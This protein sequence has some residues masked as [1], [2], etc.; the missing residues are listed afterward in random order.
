[1]K[2]RSG[3]ILIIVLLVVVVALAVG[4]SVASRNITNLRTSTQTEQSQRAFTAAEGG[5]EDVLSRLSTITSG[6]P[7]GGQTTV[8]VPVG[9]LTA[10]VSI[11]SANTYQQVIDEGNVGQIALSGGSGTVQ[12]EWVNSSDSSESGNPA[13][14]EITE[15]NGVSPYTQVR[16]AWSGADHGG[17]QQGFVDPSTT[18]LSAPYHNCTSGSGFQKCVQIDLAASP[19]FLRIRPFWNKA[20][21]MVSS[22]SGSLPAQ[23]YNITSTAS[24]QA[25]ITRKVQVTRTALPQLPASFDYVLFSEQDIV[26]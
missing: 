1:M 17:D 10:N 9:N 2:K 7:V 23:T 5:V 4:L 20:T 16:S 26:K 11:A 14:L 13:S 18:T 15:I 8:N 25:G 22:S 24:T 19:V 21:V 12:V 3:Q 6:I